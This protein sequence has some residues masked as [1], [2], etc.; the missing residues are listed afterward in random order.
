MPIQGAHLP[1]C[2]KLFAP[3][4]MYYVELLGEGGAMLPLGT[5]PSHYS[6]VITKE[7]HGETLKMWSL[8]GGKCITPLLT[9]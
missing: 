8:G 9:P 5:T 6:H 7:W 2:S 3:C 4:I 1:T